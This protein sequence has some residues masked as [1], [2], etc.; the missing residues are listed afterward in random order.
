MAGSPRCLADITAWLRSCRKGCWAPRYLLHVLTLAQGD[1]TPDPPSSGSGSVCPVWR[2]A[3]GGFGGLRLGLQGA[4]LAALGRATLGI[5][6][7]VV[8]QQ[9]RVGLL[10]SRQDVQERWGRIARGCPRGQ[11]PC[12]A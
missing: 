3:I 12:G 2:V 5:L 6:R 10:V 11:G 4:G 8:V 9:L 1:P 7:E